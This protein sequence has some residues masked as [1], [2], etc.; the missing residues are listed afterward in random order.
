MLSHAVFQSLRVKLWMEIQSM[1]YA[2]A[3][4]VHNLLDALRKLPAQSFYITAV[5][6]ILADSTHSDAKLR[7]G[8]FPRCR[9][10]SLGLS[11]AHP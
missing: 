10:A 1:A 9:R 4:G 5:I 11:I 2:V 3:F 7:W 6:D 8:L